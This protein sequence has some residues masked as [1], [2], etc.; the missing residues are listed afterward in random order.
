MVSLLP[1]HVQK[2][3]TDLLNCGD[4]VGAK[5]IY[6]QWYHYPSQSPWEKLRNDDD[7]NQ[8]SFIQ[9]PMQ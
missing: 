7:L 6:D 4:F 8:S 1:N 2:R 9:Y 3:V 5:A